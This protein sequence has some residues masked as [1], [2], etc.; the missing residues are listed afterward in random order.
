MPQL[1]NLLDAGCNETYDG[2]QMEKSYSRLLGSECPTTLGYFLSSKPTSKVQDNGIKSLPGQ[3]NMRN[4]FTARSEQSKNQHPRPS[5]GPGSWAP[6]LPWPPSWALGAGAYR[7]TLHNR[8][9]YDSEK[10]RR[11]RE[12]VRARCLDLPSPWPYGDH[13]SALKALT[14]VG[15]P[16]AVNPHPHLRR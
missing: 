9:P 2:N 8:R 14:C 6:I 16:V 13:H 1:H 10:A 4:P 12:V 15:H 5:W 11:L 7:G 3:A